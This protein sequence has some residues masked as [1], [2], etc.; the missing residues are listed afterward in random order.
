MD[1]TDQVGTKESAIAAHF[2]CW[3]SVKEPEPY[4][5]KIDFKWHSNAEA[6]Y[7]ALNEAAG[8]P[9]ETTNRPFFDPFLHSAPLQPELFCPAKPHPLWAHPG[10]DTIEQLSSFSMSPIR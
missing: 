1:A 8:G 5:K 7:V 6:C 9:T 2:C 4:E 10:D 3:L